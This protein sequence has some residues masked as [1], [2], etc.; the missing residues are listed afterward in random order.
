MKTMKNIKR[1]ICILRQRILYFISYLWVVLSGQKTESNQY[2]K[3][4]K[5]KYKGKRCFIIGNGPSLTK[6]DL[7]MLQN[8]ITFATNKI[9]QIFPQTNWRPT[10][11]GMLDEGVGMSDVKVYIQ[12]QLSHI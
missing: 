1:I 5:D 7:E 10:Y 3:E 8:E 6:A 12:S 9:Y 2:L 11:Y 4:L